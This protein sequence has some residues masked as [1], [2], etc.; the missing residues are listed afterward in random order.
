VA[1][2]V[3]GGRVNQFEAMDRNRVSVRT[4]LE[5]EGMGRQLED[6][7]GAMIGR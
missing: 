7:I 2:G 4:N 6:F 1:G 3:S 5:E